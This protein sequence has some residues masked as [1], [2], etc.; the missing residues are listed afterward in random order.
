MKSAIILVLL[1]Q[2]HAQEGVAQH[3][4]HGI[5]EKWLRGDPDPTG[6]AV[7]DVLVAVDMRSDDFE[8]AKQ[9]MRQRM[10]DIIHVKNPVQTQFRS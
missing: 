1:P 2:C 5:H 7:A 3:K 4:V 6:P 9:R 10:A 8:T